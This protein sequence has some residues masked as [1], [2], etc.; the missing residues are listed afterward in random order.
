MRIPG[1]ISPSSL[2]RF[3][4]DVDEFYI[5]YMA[6]PRPEREPQSEPAS[7]G[8]AFD[9]VV[10]SNLHHALFG[11]P[12]FEELFESQVESQN[13]TFAKKAGLH[14]F[15]NYVACGAY[16]ELLNMMEGAQQAPQFEFEA[17]VEIDGI[18]LMGKPD[19]RFV[20]KDGV[21]IILD[22]KVNGYCGKYNTSPNKGYK[23]CRD[24]LGW[25]RPSRSNDKSHNLYKDY[26]HK[27][28]TINEYFLEDFSIDWADQL[29]IYG[30][31]MG[32]TPGD[33]EVVVAIDQ[34][35]AK[36]NDDEPLLR[37][38]QHRSRVSSDYQGKLVNRLGE[39]WDAV[40]SGWLFRDVTE[41]ESREMCSRLDSVAAATNN[42][43]VA[44]LLRGTYRA[45]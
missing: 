31:M 11:T 28:L 43:E 13:R 30:W 15:R 20:N 17:N 25:P 21:H 33:E 9:A 27:G 8:S 12:T 14:V 26:V 23:L 1:Y 24:G 4:K 6:E 38:A 18:P 19:A 10:K 29:S 45:R 32:E 16:Q 36:P 5:K 34:V 2:S 7:V 39:M 37:I 22:W 41:E 42:D 40:Q 44:G 35:V 3:E